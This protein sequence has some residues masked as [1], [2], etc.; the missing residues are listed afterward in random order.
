[1]TVFVEVGML[2]LVVVVV[3]VRVK[4]GVIVSVGVSVGTISVGVGSEPGLSNVFDQTG[5]L[6]PALYKLKVNELPFTSTAP[7]P[8]S[9]ASVPIG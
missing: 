2:V 7:K 5:R 6:V 9:P 4:V 1:M 3:G 8:V